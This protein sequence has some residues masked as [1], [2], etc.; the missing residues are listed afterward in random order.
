[1]L[2]TTPPT[3]T[4]AS[5]RATPSYDT[6]DI[7]TISYTVDDGAGSGVESDSV[8]LDGA[9]ASNGQSLDMFL[10]GVGTHTV[11]VTATD[12]VDNVGSTPLVF[13]IHATAESLLANLERVNTEG[14]ISDPAVY[15]GLRDKLTQALKKH[16]AGQHAVEANV[17]GAFVDQLLAQ[18]GKGIDAAM[19]DLLIASARDIVAT[20]N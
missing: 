16:E 11:D 3:A 10:L 4:F 1:V 18:R 12:N 9:A 19:A 2:D 7:D 6:D 14:K 13:T 17:L 8:T 5:P 15:A 20:G